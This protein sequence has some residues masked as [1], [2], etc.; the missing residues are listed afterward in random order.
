MP[1]AG[2]QKLT[3][4]FTPSDTT[5]YT[6][7]SGSVTLTVNQATPAITW[8]TPASI[9]YG[10]ALSATQLDAT[11]SVAGSFSYNPAVGQVLAVGNQTLSTN[12]TPTDAVD[13]TP[14]TASVT[15]AVTKQVPTIT[16]ADPA[17]ITYGTAL[18][19]TQLNAT[20]NVAGTFAYSPSSGT[21]LTAGEQMLSVTFHADGFGQLSGRSFGRDVDGQ[22]SGT[23]HYVG[24][25]RVGGR[26]NKYVAG[27][28][29]T[30]C[31]GQ[32]AG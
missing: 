18:S 6:S 32:C 14:A 10:T 16:W 11:A 25:A 26:W 31:Y 4:T 9:S 20:A 12:F 19:A 3:V 1:A 5:D 7:A 23:R 30:G 15:L 8:A 24:D 28:G 22:Q 2:S 29:G 13:Y 17:A 27:L 21:V